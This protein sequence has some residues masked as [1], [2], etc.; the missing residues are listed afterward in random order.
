MNTSTIPPEGAATSQDDF[1]ILQHTQAMVRH[2][3]RTI[4]RWSSACAVFTATALKK[5]SADDR[6]TCCAPNSRADGRH[7]ADLR[8]RPGMENYYHKD[9]TGWSWR[10]WS[11]WRNGDA[12]EVIGVTATSH[13]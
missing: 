2:R 11:L 10:S 9:D 13:I 7:H 1:R 12:A 5:L 3:D 8:R 6:R 4:I